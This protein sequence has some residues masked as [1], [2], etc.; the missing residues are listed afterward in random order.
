[1]LNRE[2]YLDLLTQEDARQFDKT[3]AGVVLVTKP[4]VID[5]YEEYSGVPIGVIDN[6]PFFDFR[7]DL[8]ENTKTK[9]R[10][11]YCNVSYSKFG[12]A[13]LV[14]FLYKRHPLFLMNRQYRP[15][16]KKDAYEIP[17]GF[18]DP[19]DMDATYTAIRELA[20]ETNICICK[21]Q[22]K[23]TNLG[24]VHP[25]TGLSN[26]TVSLFMAEIELENNMQVKSMDENE[27]ING[28]VLLN[29]TKI[30]EMIVNDDITDAFTLAAFVKYKF[31][32][33]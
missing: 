30:T 7:L 20:E 25:D 13:I 23:L 17:R 4:Y 33:G 10:F 22:C 15:F 1:M 12:A 31:R 3:T 21:D 8:Y 32:R 9:K 24:T 14:V 2:R 19:T 29:E 16:I 27:C 18:A 6:Q 5:E 28:H 26:N 11:R